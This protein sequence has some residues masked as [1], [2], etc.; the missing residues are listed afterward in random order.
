MTTSP[1]TSPRRLLNPVVG[2]SFLLAALTL[3]GMFTAALAFG[4]GM[5]PGFGIGMVASLAVAV[6]CFR[7]GA[8]NLESIRALLHSGPVSIW[9]EPISVQEIADYHVRYRG[10]GALGQPRQVSPAQ[11]SQ[12]LTAA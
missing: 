8:T 4:S 10:T 9:A 2:Y 3:L 6:L 11:Q 5:A 12:I 7:A 1:T